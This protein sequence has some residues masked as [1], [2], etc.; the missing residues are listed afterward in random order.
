MPLKELT[1]SDCS[2]DVVE[3]VV[4]LAGSDVADRLEKLTLEIEGPAIER[5]V[6]ALTGS[7]HLRSL[8]TFSMD[9]IG[10]RRARELSEALGCSVVGGWDEETGDE[11]CGAV[12]PSSR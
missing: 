7:K 11:G 1:L 9:G 6:L 2:G 12:S 10:A 3:G 5:A 4:V 8:Q